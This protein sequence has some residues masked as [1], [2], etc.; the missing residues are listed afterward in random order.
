MSKKT[1]VRKRER[2]RRKMYK[3]LLL[4]IIVRETERECCFQENKE[5]KRSLFKSWV[6][7]KKNFDRSLR[8]EEGKKFI[9]RMRVT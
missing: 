4:F 9:E 7:Q 1:R 2:E 6:R 5:D 3:I 8:E